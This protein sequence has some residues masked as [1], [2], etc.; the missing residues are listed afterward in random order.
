[1]ARSKYYNYNIE[2]KKQYDTKYDQAIVNSVATYEQENKKK[3]KKVESDAQCN[4]AIA[5]SIETFKQE[6]KNRKKSEKEEFEKKYK[7]V[8]DA[9]IETFKQEQEKRKKLNN[10]AVSLSSNDPENN[11]AINNYQPKVANNNDNNNNN[12][13]NNSEN[14]GFDKEYYDLLSI[15][16]THCCIS[17]LS[18]N[19]LI[20]TSVGQNSQGTKMKDY[21]RKAKEVV[22][23]IMQN[24]NNNNN[25]N[26]NLLQILKKLESDTNYPN[27]D[28]NQN[29]TT[30]TINTQ[31]IEQ[32]ATGVI[33]DVADHSIQ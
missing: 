31:N 3:S 28:V 17:V 26:N 13:G 11:Q 20:R 10:D 5:N 25:C 30:D 18:A 4:Q 22:E 27:D 15:I 32:H 6:Q 33:T 8:I 12:N 24:N 14:S 7:H 19:K 1:M 29:S 16:A 23:M 21:N 2:T 9:S